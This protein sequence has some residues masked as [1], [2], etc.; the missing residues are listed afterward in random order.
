MHISVA[1]ELYKLYPEG[2]P[3]LFTVSVVW[4]SLHI[5]KDSDPSSGSAFCNEH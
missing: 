1:L 3:H 5:T 2:T 4:I